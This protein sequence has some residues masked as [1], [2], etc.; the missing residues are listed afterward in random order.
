MAKANIS[1]AWNDKLCDLWHTLKLH[2]GIFQNV[3]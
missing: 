1:N 2:S 3:T